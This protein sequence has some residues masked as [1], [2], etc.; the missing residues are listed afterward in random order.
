VVVLTDGE[1]YSY[2]ELHKLK[3]A[4]PKTHI[5]VVALGMSSHREHLERELGKS[6]TLICEESPAGIVERYIEIARKH[7]L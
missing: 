2:A 7:L 6:A 5:Y 1:W 4:Q 3:K